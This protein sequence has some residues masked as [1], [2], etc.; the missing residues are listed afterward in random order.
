[1]GVKVSSKPADGASR[2]QPQS[3][4]ADATPGHVQPRYELVLQAR[5]RRFEPCCAHLCSQVS[6][7]SD[8]V[9][10]VKETAGSQTGSQG[11]R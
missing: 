4:L 5:G 8:L 1:M 7:T 10:I 3:S 11:C 6:G 2:V 9:V